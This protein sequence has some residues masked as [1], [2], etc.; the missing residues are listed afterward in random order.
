MRF[1]HHSAADIREY[2]ENNGL[3]VVKRSSDGKSPLEIATPRAI[4]GMLEQSHSLWGLALPCFMSVSETIETE[5]VTL[6]EA[7]AGVEAA[8]A[9]AVKFL[10]VA[11]QDDGIIS[12]SGTMLPF[13]TS[14]ERA[15]WWRP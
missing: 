4:D 12:V 13:Q 1:I 11:Y 3:R 15:E 5:P 7:V 9:T 10:L 14:A 8:T 6:A 2:V